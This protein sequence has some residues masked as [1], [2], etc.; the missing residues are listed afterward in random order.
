[1]RQKTANETC[2]F[3]YGMNLLWSIWHTQI[4]KRKR[5]DGWCEDFYI[6]RHCCAT[7][8]MLRAGVLG[9]LRGGSEGINLCLWGYHR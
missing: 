4:E 6:D 5:N 7:E 8:K 3:N 2:K 9:E 1:M